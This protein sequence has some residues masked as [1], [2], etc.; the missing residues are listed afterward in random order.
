MTKRTGDKLPAS[1][2]SNLK[3]D[4]AKKR[5]SM[6]KDWK[7]FLPSIVEA[8]RQVLPDARIYIFGSAVRGDMTGASD[9]DI[10]IT[11]SRILKRALERAKIKVRIEDIAKLPYYHPF[12]FHLVTREESRPFVR[13]AGESL[14]HLYG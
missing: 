10:L 3:M 7:L 5:A 2:G 1:S 8:I 4:L 11:L 9:V 13:R 6:L 12:E 14:L